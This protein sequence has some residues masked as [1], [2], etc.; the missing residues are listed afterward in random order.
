MGAP[1]RMQQLI[2][3]D[4][5]GLRLA[6]LGVLDQEDHQEGDNRCAGIDD[7]LP[8]LGI[9]EERPRSGPDENRDDGQQK[10][11]FAACGLRRPGGNSAK[12]FA[13]A[14]GRRVIRRWLD[15]GDPR[16]VGIDNPHGSVPL[17]WTR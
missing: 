9:A 11:P 15:R 5:N 7:K 3:L 13:T 2:E 14:I 1:A 8:Y 16:Y 10:G 12:E 4:V 17:A 6:I